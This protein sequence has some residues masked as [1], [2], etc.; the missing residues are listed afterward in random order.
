M[1]TS[2]KLYLKLI[3][4]RFSNPV[5]FLLLALSIVLWYVIK[6]GY[7]YTTDIVIPVKIENTQYEV[8]CSVEGVGYQILLH[9]IAPRKN[10]IVLDPE[11]VDMLP[12]GITPGAYNI[13]SYTLQNAISKKISALKILSVE[14]TVEITPPK[15]GA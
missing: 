10:T 1:K 9:N 6:L 12:S 7:T 11:N 4:R 2:L 15:P 8:S 13:S 5:F 3:A 14:S